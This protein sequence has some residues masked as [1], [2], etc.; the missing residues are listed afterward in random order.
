M[1]IKVNLDNCV[2]CGACVPACPFGVLSIVDR[3]VVVAEGC[4]SCGACIDA[5]GMDVFSLEEVEVTSAE[6]KTA[7]GG[8]RLPGQQPGPGGQPGR[9]PHR[10]IH[11]ADTAIPAGDRHRR[12]DGA[13]QGVRPEG[14]INPQ[15]RPY[16][17]LHG[18]RHRY[19]AAVAAPDAPDLRREHHG[20][21]HLPEQAPPDGH[22]PP[23]RIQEEP[24]GHVP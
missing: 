21:D 9:P 7:R 17:G 1:A 19:R 5:C 15:H 6:S 3:K 2:G 16:S 10:G 18:A 8:R 14:S 12:G 23:A 24:G 13:G 11:Q 4:T 22:R 20:N